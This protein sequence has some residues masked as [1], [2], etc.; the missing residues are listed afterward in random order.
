MKLTPE[1]Y[2]LTIV[3]IL[4]VL[5]W[6]PYMS[7]RM[8]TRGIMRTFGNPDPRMPADPAW[9]ERARRAHANAVEN[10]VVFAPV[11]II[12]AMIGVSTPATIMAA[13]IYLWARIVHYLV[14]AAGIPIL[15]TVSYIVG[16]AATLVIA[17]AVLGHV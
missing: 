4:T 11:V 16:V 17:A 1:L 14:Y 3:A 6:V 12:A 9:A 5:M 7:A 13:K 10:L 2:A 8:L 15:R